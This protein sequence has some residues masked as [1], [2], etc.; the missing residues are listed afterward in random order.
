MSIGI[1]LKGM[2]SLH[3]KNRLDFFFEFIPQ[4]LLL[5]A[6]FGWMDILILG[7]WMN[8]KNVE[9]IT[10]TGCPDPVLVPDLQERNRLYER[11]NE[12][13]LSPAIISTMIYIFLNGAS[14]ALKN[15]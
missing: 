11:F 5:F 12:V 4:F 8:H 14:N 10:L 1:L 6:L 9:D 7:K 2:N 13:H 15:P 3:F